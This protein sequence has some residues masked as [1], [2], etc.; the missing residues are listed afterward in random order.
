M[1]EGYH[2]P[3][4]LGAVLDHLSVEKDCWYLD[5]TL[6]DGGYSLEILKLGGNIIGLDV[7]EKALERAKER[8]WKNG[9]GQERFTLIQ[10]NFRNL[11][12]LLQTDKKIQAVVFDLGV[13]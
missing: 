11:Q 13:S 5:A 4:L 12:Q 10:G 3:V 7:D 6:G 2:V 1:M 8:F 9:F